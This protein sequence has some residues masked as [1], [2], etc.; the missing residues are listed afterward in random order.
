MVEAEPV[1]H[2]KVGADG[3]LSQFVPRRVQLYNLQ[4]VGTP[5]ADRWDAMSSAPY[6]SM[7]EVQFVPHVRGVLSTGAIRKL[8]EA[9]CSASSHRLERL[10][11]V[12]PVRAHLSRSR[13]IAVSGRVPIK[14]FM[15]KKPCA[16]L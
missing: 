1:L 3:T 11:T 2:R 13:A 6:P 9:A 8:D 16:S 5:T 7:P 4:H 10:H 15:G 14:Q 12:P